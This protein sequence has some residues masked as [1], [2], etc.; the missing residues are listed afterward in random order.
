MDNKR[1]VSNTLIKIEQ[2]LSKCK[3]ISDCK[4]NTLQSV[5]TGRVDIEIILHTDT[6][7]EDMMDWLT[8]DMI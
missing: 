6:Q 4:K 7:G 8:L 3:I 1:L 2:R 5:I